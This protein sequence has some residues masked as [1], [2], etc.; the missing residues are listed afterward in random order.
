MLPFHAWFYVFLNILILLWYESLVTKAKH[1]NFSTEEAK[2]KWIHTYALSN[3][4]IDWCFHVQKLQWQLKEEK[5]CSHQYKMCLLMTFN[6]SYVYVLTRGNK[7]C[8]WFKYLIKEQMLLHDFRDHV[9]HWINAKQLNHFYSILPLKSW[10]SFQSLHRANSKGLLMSMFWISIIKCS[11]G[12]NST[13]K[14]WSI[15]HQFP[16]L[17][18][19][20][21]DGDK[22]SH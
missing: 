17:L 6:S 16:L 11:Q 2:P 7:T 4:T 12:I 13:G 3:K 15:R 8:L 1:L 19:F 18:I 5:P 22:E 10:S 14:Q 20:P 21:I 9:W